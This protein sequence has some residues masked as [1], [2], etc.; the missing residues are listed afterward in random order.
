MSE[1]G[2]FELDGYSVVCRQ[3]LDRIFLLNETA[4][5]I[6]Q[7]FFTSGDMNKAAAA[8]ADAYSLA[9]ERA[10]ADVKD[11][12]DRW[13]AAR[14]LGD[15]V[16]S[17]PQPGAVRSLPLRRLTEDGTGTRLTYGYGPCLFSLHIDSA[18]VCADLAAV[19]R[20]HFGHLE[21]PGSRVHAEFSVTTDGGDFLLRRNAV[22]V[23]QGG[24][25]VVLQALHAEVVDL[26]HQTQPWLTVLHAGAVSCVAGA[27][28]FPGVSGRGKSTLV[29]ALVAAG[30]GYLADDV[31][32]ITEQGQLQGCPLPIAVKSGSWPVLAATWPELAT[33]PSY[34]FSA[35]CLRYLLPPGV[36]ARASQELCPLR[37]IVLP[38][39]QQGAVATLR[40]INKA[41]TLAAIIEAES[42][43]C[44]PVSPVTVS[45]LVGWLRDIPCY[46]LTYDRLDEAIELLQ[47]RLA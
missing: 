14:L 11:M 44:R 40:R 23:V 16:Q 5:V 42:L 28:V 35:K 47:G 13:H 29:A 37:A 17:T 1:Y 38:N 39:Y 30:W 32:V 46:Q 4:A 6:W 25:E 15:P 31:C 18:P 21:T 33:L 24:L 10:K 19:I 9:P 20:R 26:G 2:Q 22:P 45:A 12:V 3:G 41:D 34:Q 36:S 7:L 27:L 8:L 43:V